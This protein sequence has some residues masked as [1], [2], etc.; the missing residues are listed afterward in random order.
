MTWWGHLA[1]HCFE[2]WINHIK[3]TP[4]NKWMRGHDIKMGHFDVRLWADGVY[5][6]LLDHGDIFHRF[7]VQKLP[8]LDWAESLV[9]GGR[10]GTR[11]LRDAG[12]LTFLKVSVMAG[13]IRYL[14]K[15]KWGNLTCSII[16]LSFSIFHHSLITKYK[17]R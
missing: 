1:H 11:G 6:V 8:W 5:M 16:H 9:P 2:L 10:P 17:Q 7:F 12:W 4:L 14:R 3:N 13:S 15:T